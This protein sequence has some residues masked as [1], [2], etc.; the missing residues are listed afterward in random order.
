M[1]TTLPFSLRRSLRQW[2]TGLH[3]REGSSSS[4]GLLV[5]AV[6]LGV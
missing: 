6:L 3:V 2:T 4:K 1:P 5:V